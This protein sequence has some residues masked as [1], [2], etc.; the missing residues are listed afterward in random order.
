MLQTFVGK[1]AAP[2]EAVLP[3]DF[4]PRVWHHVVVAHAPG[5][6]LSAPLATL[7]VGGKAVAAAEKLRYPKVC[8]FL[9]DCFSTYVSTPAG[10]CPR[11]LRPCALTARRLR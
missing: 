4:Q 8:S 2:S 9:L 7:Y 3:F 11:S 6:P 5:G 10:H 1:G